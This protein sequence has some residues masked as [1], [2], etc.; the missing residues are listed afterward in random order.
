MKAQTEPTVRGR[1][2]NMQD[3]PQVLLP[4][5][6]QCRRGAY[7]PSREVY[8]MSVPVIGTDRKP[9]MP[10][11]ASRARCWIKNNEAVPFFK[12]GIFCVKLIREPSANEKQK[13]AVG[14][15]P[16]SKK[17]G[18]T[19]KST[20][21]TYLNIQ[22]D[23][24]QH[25]GKTVEIRRNMRRN[26]RYRKTPYRQ[27][28]MNRAHGAL[29]PSTKSRWQWKLRIIEQLAKI[30]P[31]T[32]FVVEDIKTK[33]GSKLFSPLQIGKDWFYTQLKLFGSVHLKQGW[34][35]AE[36]RNKFGLRKTT[37]KLA[38]VF[39]AHCVDSW[40]LANSFTGYHM[41]PDNTRMIYITPI[42]LHRRQLHMRQPSKGGIRKSYGGTRSI[43]FKRGSLVSHYKYGLSYIGGTRVGR[44]SLHSLIDGR[45][46]CCNAKPSDLQF[47]AYNIWRV[48]YD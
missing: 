6:G 37:D 24:I 38:S 34:E 40:V 42:I 22:A 43:D 25:V 18:F 21:H 1:T 19:V 15:D 14:I 32:D 4:L 9:L 36:L 46:I 7:T 23:A 44:I 13:I 47:K 2:N 39:E 3:A 17:E 5:V 41:Y 30:F 16:G 12:R 31:I 29:P 48:V 35:T 20:A 27:N 10:T 11:T 8:N 28:R 45:R 33:I 26:R